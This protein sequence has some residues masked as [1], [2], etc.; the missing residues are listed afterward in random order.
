MNVMI[1]D[2][3]QSDD[4]TGRTL[5]STVQ[6]MLKDRGLASALVTLREKK[7]ANCMGDFNCWIRTPG[8]CIVRDDNI[9]LAE[10]YIG[11]DLVIFLTPVSFGGYAST[12]KRMIDHLIQNTSPFFTTIDGELHHKPRYPSYPDILTIGWL[13]E[14]DSRTESVFRHLS[15]RNAINTY[16][17]VHVSGTVCHNRSEEKLKTTV[18]ELINRVLRKEPD[19][20]PASLPDTPFSPTVFPPASRALLLVGSPRREKSTSASL[21]GYLF[22]RM[23]QCGVQTETLHIYP[24]IDTGALSASVGSSDLVVLAFPLYVDGLPAPVVAV[25]E[26]LARSGSLTASPVRF[27]AIANCGF[28]EASQNDTALAICAEFARAAGFCWMGSLS[29]GGGEGLI[30]G[31]PLEK[32][33]GRA[34][35]V[36]RA[37]DLAAQALAKGRPVPAEARELL[38]K[39]V[40]PSWLYTFFGGIGWKR[41]AA[42]FGMQKRLMERPYRH[43]VH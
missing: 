42:E 31:V 14:P 4:P 15:W 1:L 22:E 35:P 29:L 5:V 8:R 20:P 39:P 33:D 10:R 11:S 37:L 9:E 17:N 16:S 32:L 7:I 12:G 13:D 43:A 36:K 30:H 24:S 6:Q 28:P 41:Q 27:A 25:L 38:S 19:M 2:G 26:T 40:I 34:I 21:G 23:R 18:E 3:S